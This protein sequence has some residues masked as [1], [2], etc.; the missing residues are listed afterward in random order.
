MHLPQTLHDDSHHRL[1]LFAA[2][3]G[4]RRAVICFEAGRDIMDGF[5][6]TACPG[7]AV[8]AGI[9]AIMVQSA[10]RDWFLS[11]GSDHLAKALSAATAAYDEVTATGFSMG[12]Y[13]ALLYSRAARVSR[14]LLVSPQY[15]IDPRIAPYDPDRHDKFRRIGQDMPRPEE[16]GDTDLRGV[17]IYDPSIS[18]DREHAARITHVF[19]RLRLLALPYGGHPATSVLGEKGQVGKVS[20]MLVEGRL[21]LKEIRRRHRMARRESPRYHLHLARAAVARHPDRARQEL[22]ALAQNGSDHV[23]FEAGLA[24][25]PLD[26]APAMT[27]LN[28]LFDGLPDI[29]ASWA[30]RLQAA[31]D[32]GTF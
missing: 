25:L 8:R 7:F 9:D 10:R 22:L 24:L 12:G 32:D 4:S 31:L 1:T 17:L 19:P 3:G 26:R 11:K 13:G 21:R 5:V 29:P 23:R 6:P 27:A 16:W 18:A 28:N 2:P 30:R 20:I 14:A 15:S